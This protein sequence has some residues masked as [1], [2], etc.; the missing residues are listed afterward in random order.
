MNLAKFIPTINTRAQFGQ[1]GIHWGKK[2]KVYL[3]DLN[4]DELVAFFY[5]RVKTHLLFAIT[6]LFVFPANLKENYMCLTFCFQI[7]SSESFDYGVTLAGGWGVILQ[8]STIPRCRRFKIGRNSGGVHAVNKRIQLGDLEGDKKFYLMGGRLP[9]F[10]PY[11]RA[12]ADA[13]TQIARTHH[14]GHRTLD[15][16]YGMFRILEKFGSED[17]ISLQ[18]SSGL[19]CGTE[20]G[21]AWA[22]S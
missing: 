7:V 6:P 21:S 5:R 8:T 15:K 18:L 2:K 11:P 3:R 4:I 14:P 10:S 13:N 16:L 17:G 9:Q 1:N 19:G 12:S 22:P 20:K